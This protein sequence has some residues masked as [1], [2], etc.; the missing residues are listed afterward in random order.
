MKKEYIHPEIIRITLPSDLL[1]Q[2]FSTSSGV[3]A[4]PG[5]ARAPLHHH[6]E[7]NNDPEWDRQVN[8]K[9]YLQARLAY[10]G[11]LSCYCHAIGLD[12]SALF[13]YIY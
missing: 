2:N 6:S 7:D 3:S 10:Q 9:H 5:N 1:G 12:V 11:V 4:S 8:N 13:D